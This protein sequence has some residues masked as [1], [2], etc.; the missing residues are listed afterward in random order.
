MPVKIDSRLPARK[1]L[2]EENI[3]VMTE[4]RALSQEIRA[5]R[6]EVQELELPVVILINPFSASS[7]EIF[8][9]V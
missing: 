2:E 7:S 9:I 6:G 1:F 5:K 4:E 3:F 8:A